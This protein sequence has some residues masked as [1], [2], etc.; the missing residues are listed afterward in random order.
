MIDAKKTIVF[1]LPRGEAIKN[2]VLSGTAALVRQKAHLVIISIIPN[3]EIEAVMRNNCDEFYELKSLQMGPVI[4][5]LWE[6]IDIVHGRWL[7]SGAAKHR[8]KIRDNEVNSIS[9]KVSRFAKKIFAYP[10]TN[11]TGLEILTKIETLGTRAAFRN[12]DCISLLK[13]I[14]PDLVFN[15]SHIHSWI[16]RPLMHAAKKLGIKTATFLFSW[17]NL[18]S[19]GRILP[20]YDYYMVWN[21]DIKKDLLRI[22]HKISPRQVLVTGTPQFDFHFNKEIFS[23]REKY[24]QSIGADPA[25]PII[26]YTTGMINLYP[27][28][29]IIVER[30]A[31]M[32]QK[33]EVKPQLVV[34][35][36]PKDTTGRYDALKERR[37]D[38][39]FPEIIWERNYFTPMPEDLVTYSNMLLHC[40]V[41]I[42]ASSTVSLELCMF[43]KPVINIGYNPPGVDIFPK[44]Y[45]IIYQWDH[46][47]PLTDSGALDIAWKEEE[48]YG[49][50]TNALGH[51]EHKRKERKKLVENFFGPY[52][53]GKSYLRIAEKLLELASVKN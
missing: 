4:G 48:M 17:D 2:F 30:I 37:K 5:Y 11:R 18:T 13:K 44:D 41:G 28:E 45:A 15:G 22:Y 42:N 6:W 38:I 27:F 31:D 40:D 39:I 43:D 3:S 14:K 46:Y 21:D 36:Y 19:Q 49:L 34:R 33:M 20:Y 10:F 29:E 16:A 7:W 24:A 32:L 35:L 25:K 53:D 50:I 8:W 23:T 47:K 9:K 51:P 1:V 26:M 12:Q 52:L